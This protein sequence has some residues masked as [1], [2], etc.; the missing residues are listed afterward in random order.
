MKLD[1][2]TGPVGQSQSSHLDIKVC[3]GESGYNYSVSDV[4]GLSGLKLEKLELLS[5]NQD[6]LNQEG[7]VL[8]SLQPI[9]I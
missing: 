9:D 2:F 7:V 4:H 1:P 6:G 5:L 3:K 8:V